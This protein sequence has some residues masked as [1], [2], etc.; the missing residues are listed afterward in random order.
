L[1]RLEIRKN[2]DELYGEFGRLYEMSVD[3]REWQCKMEKKVNY[4][5]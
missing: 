3:K 1:D 2:F 5:K 4:S